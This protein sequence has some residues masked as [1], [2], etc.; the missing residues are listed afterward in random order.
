M[1]KIALLLV[2]ISTQV[3]AEDT[4][5]L[6][7]LDG[8]TAT[9]KNQEDQLRH[10][11]G[12]YR[13]RDAKVSIAVSNSKPSVK[14][15]LNVDS[16][17][18]A[19]THTGFHF[20]PQKML[21]TREVFAR[22]GS[23]TTIQTLDARLKGTVD[24]IYDIIMEEVLDNEATQAVA[25]TVPVDQLPRIQGKFQIDI[26]LNKLLR[27]TNLDNQYDE[28]ENISFGSYRLRF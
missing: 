26:W 28:V 1:K 17:K 24:G 21:E 16:F 8:T 2:L 25:F 22:D 18:C 9:C 15:K 12:V 10:Q 5:V 6:R 19:R 14:V 20:L 27:I 11:N 4:Q 13:V 7:V 23:M 3:F